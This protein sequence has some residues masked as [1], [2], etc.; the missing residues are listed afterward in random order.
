MQISPALQRGG[1]IEKNGKVPEGRRSAFT[2]EHDPGRT[3]PFD[4][5][6]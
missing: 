4:T 6:R 1:E 2:S 5:N 3:I